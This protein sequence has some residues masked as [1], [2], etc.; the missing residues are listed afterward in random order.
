M[1]D[2]PLLQDSPCGR[3]KTVPGIGEINPAWAAIKEID[4]QF[5]FQRANMAAHRRLRHAQTP[6]RFGEVEFLRH[7]NEATKVMQLN[8]SVKSW[9]REWGFTPQPL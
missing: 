1:R 8:R 6:S 2:I 3:K 5:I 9:P 7:G 4:T